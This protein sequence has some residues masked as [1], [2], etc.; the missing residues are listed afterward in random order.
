MKKIWIEINVADND[1]ESRQIAIQGILDVFYI[2]DIR[3]MSDDKIYELYTQAWTFRFG[4][5]WGNTRTFLSKQTKH[6]NDGIR[7]LPIRLPT[8]K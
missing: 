5:D 8:I 4:D 6:N 3:E 7:R 2:M 1:K